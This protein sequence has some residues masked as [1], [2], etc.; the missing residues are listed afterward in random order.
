MLSLLEMPANRKKGKKPAANP[1][2]GFATTSSAAKPRAPADEETA[3]AESET[4]TD[5]GSKLEKP[6]ASNEV[7]ESADEPAAPAKELADLTPEQL[8]AQLEDSELELFVEKYGAKSKQDAQR[9][10]SRLQTE[11]RLLRAQGERLYLN[12]WIG[13]ELSEKMLGMIDAE[14]SLPCASG[15]L[16]DAPDV[17]TDAMIHRAWSLR[18]AL[19]GLGFP[20]DRTDEAVRHNF[21]ELVLR[22]ETESKASRESLWGLESCL[23]WLAATYGRGGMPGYDSH[24]SMRDEKS[25]AN[26]L[27]DGGSA[28]LGTIWLPS[29]LSFRSDRTSY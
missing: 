20:D 15:P 21:G 19:Q 9:H 12:S 16:A 23:D 8:E 14:R 22:G 29:S 26:A 25:S 6:D 4:T 2:R 13:D 10:V 18:R 28:P 5:P 7:A 27:L 3:R 17:V 1:A 24:K 11:R